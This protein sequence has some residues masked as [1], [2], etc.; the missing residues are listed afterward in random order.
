MK[1]KWSTLFTDIPWHSILLAVYGPL[2]LLAHNLGQVEM[3][4]GIRSIMLSL[5]IALLLLGCAYLALKNRTLAGAVVSL[6]I[7]LGISYGHIYQEIKGFE[8]FGMV[9]GRHRFLVLVWSVLLGVVGWWAIKKAAGISG[10]TAKLNLVAVALLLVPVYQ[11]GSYLIA[12][13]GQ[14]QNLVEKFAIEA[15]YKLERA[16]GQSYPDVYYI[17]LDAYSRSD[18]MLKYIDFDN[19]YFIQGL[20]EMGFYVAE[21][22]QSNYSKTDLSLSSS[23]NLNYVSALGESFVPE[24]KDRLP[25]WELIKGNQVK[26]MFEDL[27][28][29]TVAFDTGY[30]FTELESADIY[31]YAPKKG[32]N[33]F[34]N[35]YLKTTIASLL[36]DA[37]LFRKYQLTDEDRKRELVLYKLDELR[38]VPDI[39]GPKFVFVHLVIPHPPFVFGADGEAIVIPKRE[40]KGQGYYLEEDYLRGY[41]EQAIF[42]SDQMLDVVSEILEKSA[43]SP[44]IV[45]QGDHGSGH[46]DDKD[47][48][49]ILN[50]YHFPQG[51]DGLYPHITPVNTFRLIFNTYFGADFE[52]LPDVSYDSGYPYPYQYKRIDNTC[53]PVPEE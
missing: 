28:Y 42:I 47:N 40:F 38:Q 21:C 50:A 26:A 6:I 36:D 43:Q 17:I 31:Y 22:A 27:G 51:P 33:S 16:A 39:P 41:R 1:N 46:F 53:V 14:K 29:T 5:V 48:V 11:V 13:Q 45:I 44:I 4:D 12:S 24:S 3:Q 10:L 25:L 2:A 35:L 8:L 52:L 15:Q 20:E 34:E 7:L 19:T 18:A 30:D 23:M 37:G 49:T 9:L 32:F